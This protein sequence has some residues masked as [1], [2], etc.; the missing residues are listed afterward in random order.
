M[1][2]NVFALK[3]IENLVKPIV[4]NGVKE[5][6]LFGFYARGEAGADSD[7]DNTIIQ[8]RRTCL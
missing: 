8:Y 3:D 4:K 2:D 1:S 6:D 5:I 7:L